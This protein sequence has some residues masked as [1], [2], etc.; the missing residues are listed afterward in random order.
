MREDII[1]NDVES[2]GGSV[3]LEDRFDATV[4][5]TLA[6]REKQIQQSYRPIIGV[7]KWFARWRI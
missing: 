6:L 3:G 1:P 2:S 5:A 7:H 4:A